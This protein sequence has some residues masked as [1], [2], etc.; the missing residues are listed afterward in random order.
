MMNFLNWC[1]RKLYKLRRSSALVAVLILALVI[2]RA[3]AQSVSKKIHEYDPVL[4]GA[5]PQV[6]EEGTK[7]QSPVLSTPGFT[8]TILLPVLL[9]E[10]TPT[11]AP[12]PT[13]TTPSQEPWL[14]YLNIF[15]TNTGLEPLVENDEWSDGGWLHSRYMVKNDYVGHS[16]DPGNLWYSPAGH[17]AAQNGNVFVTSWA[18]APDEMPI[19]FW[20]TAPFHAVSMIDPQLHA[21]GFGIYRETLGLWKTGSTLDVRRGLGSLP[22]GTIFPIPYPADGHSTWLTSYYGGEFPDPLTSCPGYSPPTGAPI[23][24]QLGSGNVT[25][26][27]TGHRVMMNGTPVETCLFDETSYVNPDPTVQ[28][29]G[30]IVLNVRDAIVIMPKNPLIPG[31]TYTVEITSAGSTSAWNFTVNSSAAYDLNFT[32][33]RIQ[34][35]QPSP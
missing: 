28:S 17:A 14:D 33:F 20:M 27:V 13:P 21:S 31:S 1:S 22:Q 6:I 4:A 9:F 26:Q 32:P 3:G 11:T 18:E 7:G 19:D 30:R 8:E 12:H 35:G 23:I 2:G 15:R 5:P 25:P 10:P 16:E 29:T 24:L 34:I